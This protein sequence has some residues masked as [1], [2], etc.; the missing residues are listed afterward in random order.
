VEKAGG[1]VTTRYYSRFAIPKIKQ[2]LM[3]PI[4]SLESRIQLPGQPAPPAPEELVHSKNGFQYRL[5]DPTSRK[6]LEYYRDEAHRGYL[7]HAVEEGQGPSLFF[8]VPEEGKQKIVRRK[9]KPG[10]GAENRLW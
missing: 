7:S 3:D 6:A 2:G 4:H 1:T 5:P 8:K 10:T 9:R